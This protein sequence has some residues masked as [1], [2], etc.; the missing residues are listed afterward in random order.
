MKYP[1]FKIE[2]NKKEFWVYRVSSPSYKELI[3][4]T[5]TRQEAEHRINQRVISLKDKSG[6]KK[7]KVNKDIFKEL[8]KIY[9]KEVFKE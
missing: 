9:R 5:Q 7:V 3:W 6:Q 2:E 4:I 8:N 1:Y